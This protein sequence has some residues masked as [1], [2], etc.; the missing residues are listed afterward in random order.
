VELDGPNAKVFTA[1]ENENGAGVEKLKNVKVSKDAGDWKHAL[2]VHKPDLPIL[3]G[4]LKTYFAEA[5]KLNCRK[6]CLFTEEG[7][8]LLERPRKKG[9]GIKIYY[10]PTSSKNMAKME[11]YPEVNQDLT[12]TI[13]S[14]LYK[15]D[16][17]SKFLGKAPRPENIGDGNP[18]EEP[19]GGISPYG[20]PPTPE[21]DYDESDLDAGSYRD[22][23]LNL[24]PDSDATSI[25]SGRRSIASLMP[26]A[27][28]PELNPPAALSDE[29]EMLV[30]DLTLSDTNKS[31]K[32]DA[33]RQ[34][35]LDAS[36]RSVQHIPKQSV[37][38]TVQLEQL[39]Q[40]GLLKQ[41]YSEPSNDPTYAQPQSASPI[42]GLKPPIF[43]V[44][45][46]D[47]GPSVQ[48]IVADMYKETMS[49][50]AGEA[51][52]LKET[53]DKEREKIKLIEAGIKETKY[54]S[55]ECKADLLKLTMQQSIRYDRLESVLSPSDGKEYRNPILMKII[56]ESLDKKKLRTIPE[57]R[58]DLLKV[59]KWHANEIKET[60]I[61][62]VYHIDG[63]A[64]ADSVKGSF[65][66]GHLPRVTVIKSP[67]D[68]PEK[69]EVK[70]TSDLP[71]KT[72]IEPP[73]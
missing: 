15:Q 18:G 4:I 35:L 49:H 64:D 56:K 39:P 30:F 40:P 6:L 65:E 2:D 60:K 45:E 67:L 23:G 68:L 62:V 11:T 58:E 37:Q 47:T 44:M 22:P 24:D 10:D 9:G 70:S 16:I 25:T 33:E 63:R 14:C 31:S 19:S 38:H 43:P 28:V 13:L 1:Y 41:S 48:E 55:A 59:V 7:I 61:E 50:L 53:L 26:D 73:L 72:E 5:K 51:P 46:V 12:K 52:G 17:V 21:C 69:T 54:F 32:D 66:T 3:T 27:N 34:V 8:V 20:P 57:L 42:H 36:R 71:A 29:E